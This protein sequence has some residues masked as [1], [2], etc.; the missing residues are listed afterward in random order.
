MTCDDKIFFIH[1]PSCAGTTFWSLLRKVYGTERVKRIRKKDFYFPKKNEEK[2]GDSDIK[3]LYS[4]KQVIGG[5]IP[6]FD[7]QKKFPEYD[8][9][10]KYFFE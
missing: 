2:V 7:A 10:M 3:K 9:V 6:Y 5:H 1:I 8:F 4:N